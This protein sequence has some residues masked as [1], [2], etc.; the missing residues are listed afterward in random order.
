MKNNVQLITY[1]DRLTGS[2]IKELNNI[3]K[4]QLTDLF[5]GIHL[6]PFYYPIDGS[7]AGFDPIDHTK[8]DSRLGSWQDVKILGEEYDLMADLIVNHMSAQSK[9]FQDVLSNGK[10]SAYWDLFLTKEKVFP[11][12]LDKVQQEN[13]Y[14][15]RPGSCFTKFTLPENESSDFWTTFTDNQIDIDV[16]SQVG[17]AYLERILTTFSESKIKTIRL[18]AAGYA[19]KKA[20]SSCFMLEE[21]FKFIDELTHKANKLDIE[22]LVEIHSY[23]QT[24]IEIAKRV[25]QVYDFALPPLI[26]HS[27][28]NKD[29]SALVNWLTISPRNCITVLDTHDG[30]GII[31]VGPM[32]GKAGLLTINQIDALVENI[33]L[34]SCGQSKLATGAAASNVDLYQVNCTYYDALGKNDFDYLVARAIQFFAPGTPQVYY[35]GLLAQT[36]DMELLAKSQ[37]GRDINRPYLNSERIKES[38]TKPITKALFALIGIRNNSSAFNGEFSVYYKDGNLK[39]SWIKENDSAVLS[40]NSTTN[41]AVINISEAGLNRSINLQGLLSE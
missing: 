10:K 1:V 32:D 22:T 23:Y 5:S 27:L 37:I 29:F 12:G 38:L 35:A 18:D 9:E 24:Q 20:G 11:N 15:P 21:T 36:N 40:I 26:L 25:D 41:Y 8:V 14:R 39:M 16:T 7:D 13:I 6:L 3:L 31:D 19:I 17:Q 2:T 28:F 33:H 34:K 4:N 30:I